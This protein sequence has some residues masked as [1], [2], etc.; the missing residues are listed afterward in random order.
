MPLNKQ[1]MLHNNL[2]NQLKT[3][4]MQLSKQHLKEIH[5]V[6]SKR[7][8]KQYLMQIMLNNLEM[9]HNNRLAN[10]IVNLIEILIRH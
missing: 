1:P 2:P 6:H 4:L 10:K 3:L 8:K 7:L 9:K 5:R